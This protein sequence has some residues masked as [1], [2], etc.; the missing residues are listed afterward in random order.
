MNFDTLKSKK[1]RS[2]RDSAIEYWAWGVVHSTS[3]PYSF[4]TL[5]MVDKKSLP[6]NNHTNF[7][8]LKSQ[9][10]RSSRDSAIEY[11]AWGVVHSTSQ[12]YCFTTLAM[13][14]IGRAPISN[15]TNFDTLKSQKFRSSR[16]SAIEYWAWGVVHS[17]SQPYCFTTLAMGAKKS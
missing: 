8:T 1:L 16:D 14:E 6:K 17:T 2:S 10:F 11:W 13:G 7:D 5:A 4:T 12:P 9:K 15:N 3:Q